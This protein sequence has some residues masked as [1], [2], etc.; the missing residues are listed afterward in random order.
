MARTMAAVQ[1]MALKK[2]CGG[3]LRCGRWGWDGRLTAYMGLRLLARGGGVVDAGG[4]RTSGP[5]WR[6]G[7]DPW[8]VWLGFVEGWQ[9]RRNRSHSKA[10]DVRT[11][12]VYILICNCSI[13]STPMGMQPSTS[14][15]S[16]CLAPTRL[17]AWMPS[18]TG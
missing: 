12:T 6:G 10:M 13:T 8:R 11:S 3:E 15:L 16:C 4:G 18:E 5:C 9:Q 1:P 7:R 2:D 14:P 17:A